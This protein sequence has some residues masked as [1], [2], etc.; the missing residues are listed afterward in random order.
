MNFGTYQLLNDQL[1][2]LN[3]GASLNDVETLENIWFNVDLTK[4]E[5]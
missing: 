2:Q 3:V 1:I 5:F 4:S